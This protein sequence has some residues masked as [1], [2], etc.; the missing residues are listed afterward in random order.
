MCEENPCPI[1]FR[2]ARRIRDGNVA[3][4]LKLGDRRG[5]AEQGVSIRDGNVA[6]LLKLAHLDQF[7]SLG[8]RIRDGNVAALLKPRV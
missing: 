5:T 2:V 6:A 1:T 7:P 3:A 4:L 8:G